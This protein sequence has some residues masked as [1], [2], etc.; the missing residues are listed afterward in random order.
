MD[1]KVLEIAEEN[2]RAF[3]ENTAK[4]IARFPKLDRY[5]GCHYCSEA[6][7]GDKLFCGA[8]CAAD[9]EYEQ[10]TLKAQGR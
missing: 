3:V 9:Y 8:E 2:L 7:K 6:V 5:G 4:N 1:E 10:K